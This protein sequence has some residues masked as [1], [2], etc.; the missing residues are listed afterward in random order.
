[1]VLSVERDSPSPEVGAFVIFPAVLEPY[2]T[3]RLPCEVGIYV[4]TGGDEHGALIIHIS[5]SV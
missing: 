2:V 4:P 1:M 3:A 5:S